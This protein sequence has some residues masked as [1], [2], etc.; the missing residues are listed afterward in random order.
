[1]TTASVPLI[2][3][4]SL[5]EATRRRLATPSGLKGGDRVLGFAACIF[6]D[7][8]APHHT[9]EHPTPGG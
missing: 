7:P 9:H 6:D 5:D 4:A 3:Y 8:G 2:D 1:V